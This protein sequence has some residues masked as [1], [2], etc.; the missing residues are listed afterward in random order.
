MTRILAIAD[1]VD[2]SLYTDK[3]PGLR[4]D[5]VVSCGDLPFDYLEYVVSRL[6]VPVVYVPRTHDPD[7]R[8][9]DPT[10]HSRETRARKP[11][12]PD[13]RFLTSRA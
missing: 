2:E 12:C 11:Q 6:N 5:V 9:P 1:E 10:R 13:D 4:P 8:T 7:P 3:L